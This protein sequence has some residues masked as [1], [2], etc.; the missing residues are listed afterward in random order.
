M[1]KR[2]FIQVIQRSILMGFVIIAASLVIC[3]AKKKATSR[4]DTMLLTIM[5]LPDGNNLINREDVEIAIERAFGYN[6]TGLPIEEIDV[7]RVERVL[8]EEAFIEGADVFIDAKN[9]VNISLTQREPI[10]RIID[11]E[12]FNYYLDKDG[13]KM[14]LSP[15]FT[16]RVP[17]ATGKI[18]L[19]EPDY[20]E[21][22]QNTIKDIF[23]LTKFIR[24]HTFLNAMVEQIYIDK[25][26]QIVLIP[27]IGRQKI[28]LGNLDDLEEK[29][30]NLEVYY[31]EGVPY[32][33]WQKYK[34]INLTF[35]D[36]VVCK[37]RR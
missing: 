35:K 12:D 21:R 28:I 22:K 33:G 6:L 13:F 25:D 5:P 3:S 36:Q 34:T 32:E 15:H 4:I 18:Q 9:H 29:I 14:P 26:Q 37:K 23:L 30:D 11:E 8:E 24:N 7:D 20:L 27:K 1:S 31:K 2:D 10:V 16:A 17:V 19:F